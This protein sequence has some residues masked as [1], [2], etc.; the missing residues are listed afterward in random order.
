M[1]L[2]QVLPWKWNREDTHHTNFEVVLDCCQELSRRRIG[3][4]IVFANTSELKFVASSGE[5]I[6]ANITR[7]IL[8][9]IFAKNSPLH[10]GAVIIANN[11][12]KAAGAVL[13][14]TE[15]PDM[16][17]NVGLRHKAAVG[18]TEQTDAVVVIVSEQTGKISM[19]HEGQL[20][21]DTNTKIILEVLQ[22]EFPI[23]EGA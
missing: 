16:P 22:A 5:M 23:K 13:P 8:E 12:I 19:A 7:H 11:R 9:C 21:L 15:N 3:A 17:V 20:I 10:D 4:I 6:D 18:I 2:K 14:V 1:S